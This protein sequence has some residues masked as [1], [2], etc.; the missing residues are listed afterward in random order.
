[1]DIKNLESGIQERESNIFA[2]NGRRGDVK[3]T[4]QVNII[5]D[6]LFGKRKTKKKRIKLT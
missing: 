5:Q 4:F 1:M 3:A 6:S 2:L